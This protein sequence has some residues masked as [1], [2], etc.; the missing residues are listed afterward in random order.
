VVTGSRR[1]RAGRAAA[2]ASE[3]LER[4]ETWNGLSRGDRV[5]VSGLRMKGATWEFRA[6]VFNRNNGTESIEVIGGRTGERSIRS[7]GPERIFAAGGSKSRN[8][9]S[10]RSL[11]GQLSLAD[12]PQLPLYPPEP[13]SGRGDAG[14]PACRRR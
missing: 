5:I 11:S 6:R 7:F 9:D 13:S 10:D 12:A 4:S 2:E 8:R 1:A 3:H 14:R